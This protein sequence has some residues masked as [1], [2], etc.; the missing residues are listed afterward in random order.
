M[1]KTFLIGI[2][3]VAVFAVGCSHADEYANANANPATRTGPDNSEITSSVDASGTKT[4][5]RTFKNNPN[6]SKVVV[7]T[8]K[9]GKRTVKVYSPSGQ[10]KEVTGPESEGVLET[11]GE[12]VA[13]GAGFVAD[14]AED[15]GGEVK[16]GAETAADKTAETAKDVANKTVDTTKDVT[17]KT[18]DVTKTVGEKTASGTKKAVKETESGVKK[19]GSAVKKVI[20]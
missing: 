17:K 7:T 1:H 2:L 9:E 3:L 20:P 19:A 13:S 4:E 10:E 8:T 14:K 15:V 5:T 6:V 18:V 12:K 16:D 11:T